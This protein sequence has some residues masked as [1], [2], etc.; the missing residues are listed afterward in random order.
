MVIVIFQLSGVYCTVDARNL[1]Y[2]CPPTPKAREEGTP[3]EIVPGPY[4]NLLESMV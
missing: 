3:A 2:G 1:E 4:S